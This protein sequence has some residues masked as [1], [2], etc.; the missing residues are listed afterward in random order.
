LA[1]RSLAFHLRNYVGSR[2]DLLND[3][4]G[5]PHR[6]WLSHLQ[7]G[8]SLTPSSSLEGLIQ[9][10]SQIRLDYLEFSREHG[11]V[12]GK[13]VDYLPAAV[14]LLG[15]PRPNARR[16]TEARTMV[17][18]RRTADPVAAAR[19]CAPSAT[20]RCTTPVQ[21]GSRRAE[22]GSGCP[23]HNSRPPCVV[24]LPAGSR[25]PTRRRIH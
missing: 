2:Q 24:L 18:T 12:L 11:D 3:I 13:I 21:L 23:P 5:S 9:K 20:Q 10:R 19:C 8:L 1:L 17:L 14:D 6:I 15:G 22:L 16:R 7:L 25:R 4:I